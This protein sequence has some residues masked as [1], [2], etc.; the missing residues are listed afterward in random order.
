MSFFASDDY[1]LIGEKKV[2]FLGK[3]T[4]W[5]PQW[6]GYVVFHQPAAASSCVENWAVTDREAGYRIINTEDEVDKGDME[7]ETE[8]KLSK[9]R[10]RL[11]N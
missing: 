2:E 3:E 4:V 6:I 1:H 5:R 7:L 10:K 8:K 11:R 9:M